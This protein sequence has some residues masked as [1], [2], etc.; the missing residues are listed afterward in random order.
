MEG[1]IIRYI[2]RSYFFC[3]QTNEYELQLRD[4]E[5]VHSALQTNSA[6]PIGRPEPLRSGR[7]FKFSTLPRSLDAC[8]LLRLL[9]PSAQTLSAMHRNTYPLL[10][11]FHID[12]T[13]RRI[14]SK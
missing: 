13:N 3:S 7:L 12:V 11:S 5:W 14:H 10:R 1:A 9:A 2:C 8:H 6:L 4:N